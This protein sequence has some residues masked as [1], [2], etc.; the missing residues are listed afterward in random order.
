METPR[1]PSIKNK[2]HTPPNSFSLSLSSMAQLG[3]NLCLNKNRKKKRK[4]ERKNGKT[5]R[6]KLD[7]FKCPPTKPTLTIQHPPLSL[8]H[9]LSLSL[10]H[11]TMFPELPFCKPPKNPIFIT[12]LSKE[13]Y[14]SPSYV[15]FLGFFVLVRVSQRKQESENLLTCSPLEASL[16][17]SL[18]LLSCASFLLSLFLSHVLFHHPPPPPRLLFSCS[19]SAFHLW[20]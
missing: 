2:V 10:S 20:L 19:L 18:F 14:F 11:R 12:G 1:I 3:Q 5:K 4:M 6:K 17:I 15:G 7:V 13:Q 16:S 8:S 9:S